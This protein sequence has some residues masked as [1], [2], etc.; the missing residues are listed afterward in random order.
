MNAPAPASTTLTSRPMVHRPS[1][2]PTAVG[3]E[4]VVGKRHPDAA[5]TK[6]RIA[7]IS[8]PHAL[9]TE[10]GF[11]GERSRA[12]IGARAGGSSLSM[13]E[14]PAAGAAYRTAPM[15]AP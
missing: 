4:S 11:P 3:K 15:A 7:A 1:S 10:K 6:S 5:G 8:A 12:V 9:E 2:A 14:A 13:T